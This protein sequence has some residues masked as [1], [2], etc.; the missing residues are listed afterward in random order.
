MND[1]P[2]DVTAAVATAITYTAIVTDNNSSII[3]SSLT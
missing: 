1:Y 2:H 3:Y